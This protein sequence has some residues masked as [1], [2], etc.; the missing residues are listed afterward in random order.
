MRL[1]SSRLASRFDFVKSGG[2]DLSRSPD[3][4]IY[5]KG[6]RPNVCYL[7]CRSEQ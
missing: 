2:D 1:S 7:G 4:L 3:P 6:L 5:I